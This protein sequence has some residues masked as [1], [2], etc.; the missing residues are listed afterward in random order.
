MYRVLVKRRTIRHSHHRDVNI[1]ETLFTSTWYRSR[2][3]A[4]GVARRN[5]EQYGE[6]DTTTED[7]EYEKCGRC[8]LTSR[9]HVYTIVESINSSN[10][11]CDMKHPC[12]QSHLFLNW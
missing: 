1:D 2:T 3:V 10:L 12:E 5:T 11:F 4:I 8:Q 7:S 6:W 9:Q